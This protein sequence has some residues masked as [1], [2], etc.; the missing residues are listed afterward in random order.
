MFVRLCRRDPKT[1]VWTKRAALSSTQLIAAE[2]AKHAAR[3]QEMSTEFEESKPT[4]AKFEAL[5]KGYILR[6]T[7]LSN[8]LRLRVSELA[9]K[10]TEA[11]CLEVCPVLAVG[12]VSAYDSLAQHWTPWV[13]LFRDVCP[14]GMS[15]VTGTPATSSGWRC[16]RHPRKL[17]KLRA[18]ESDHEDQGNWL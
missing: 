9:K 7:H 1:G 18:L 4:L 3:F 12:R 14:K 17:P 13:G 16:P 2:K 10:T 6:D 15:S 5:V 11:A 8:Q